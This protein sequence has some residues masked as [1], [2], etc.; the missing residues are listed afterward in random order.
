MGFFTIGTKPSTHSSSKDW[1]ENVLELL[2]TMTNYNKALV[3]IITQKQKF[4]E[5]YKK[6]E[7]CLSSF[8]G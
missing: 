4:S 3:Q 1:T 8:K 6:S 7:G 5:L 2:G